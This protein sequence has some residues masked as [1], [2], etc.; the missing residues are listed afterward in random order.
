M[1]SMPKKI[2]I[3]GMGMISALGYSPD[4]T[5][6]ALQKP[7][8]LDTVKRFD[9][10]LRH[11][12]VC[13]VKA[14]NAAL[15]SRLA[16]TTGGKEVVYSRTSLLALWAV[17]QALRA[18]Q[19]QVPKHR[20]G[21]VSS[22]TVGGMDYNERCF[23]DFPDGESGRHIIELLDCADVTQK[24]AV[25][26]GLSYH[27]ATV[28]TAC[29]SSSN[30]LIA[31]AR[32]I[33]SGAVDKVIA[34]GADAL[35]RFT[36]NG[37]NTLEILS[38]TGCKPFDAARNGV[39]LGEGAA[40]L[41]LEAPE[42]ACPDDVLCEL[43]GYA[44]TSEAYHQTASAPDGGG[45]VLSMRQA[46]ASAG[47]EAEQVD[48]VI[49]HG[50]GTLVNDLSEGRAIETVFGARIPPVTSLKGYTGHTLAAAGAMGAVA[51]VLAIRH[52]R[53]FPNAGFTEAMPEL[54]FTPNLTFAPAEVGHVIANSFG[55][56]GSNA[57]LLFSKPSCQ[58]ASHPS[59]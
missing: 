29:S 5:L 1:I 52:R 20:M 37:F 39:T 41:V 28:S 4:E 45:A 50:T 48:Y 54:R 31:G 44:N 6:E 25:D 10:L 3:T 56:G 18:S 26:V 46:L 15:R 49:A 35:T 51:A 59:A 30:A 53:L 7:R 14:G 33:R 55:F 13:E 34:G 19:S 17:R 9:T 38:P 21:L 43:S 22:T 32:M 58:P 27:V 40:Y 16:L 23:P 36:L 42:T 8:T 57:S 24:V 2:Y 12:P 47:L 11:I